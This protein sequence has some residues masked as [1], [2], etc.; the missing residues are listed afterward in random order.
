MFRSTTGARLLSG[1]SR[2]GGCVLLLVVGTRDVVA[3]AGE[4][5]RGVA[6]GHEAV[7]VRSAGVN[8]GDQNSLRGAFA[9]F[10]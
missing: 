3:W 4:N 6:V 9:K 5:S 10:E 7:N 2:I 1:R 8:V